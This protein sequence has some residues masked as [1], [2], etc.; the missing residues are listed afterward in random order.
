MA[1]VSTTGV[2]DAWTFSNIN[3]ANL[4]YFGAPQHC[5][6]D[7]V[8]TYQSSPALGAGT[9]D[10]GGGSTGSWHITG[11]TTMHGTMAAGL[12]KVYLVTG[13]VTVDAD[14]KYPASYSGAS[15][16]PSL[17][18]IAT[19]NIY[20]NAGV[21]Q[22]D[23]V[24]ITR[25]TFYTCYPKAEP[26]T[27]STCSNAL[28]INGSV[29]ATALDLFRTAGADGATAAAQKAPAETFTLQPEVYITNALNLST[30]TVLTTSN[31]RELPPRF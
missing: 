25:G 21:Q 20:V 18:I 1:L 30:Q 29:S 22:M 6:T 31:V 10:V 14:L 5:I 7:Y 24:F 26:A 16:I 2:G 19:G 12:Q 28:T 4:G 11:D 3:P 15:Q 17:V 27:I 8:S 13:N 9:I 23:G